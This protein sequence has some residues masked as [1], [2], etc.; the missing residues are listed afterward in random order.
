MPP[1]FHCK[2]VIREWSWKKTETEK[3]R[4]SLEKASI[5]FY[6]ETSL[7][8][9]VDLQVKRIEKWNIR[10]NYIEISFFYFC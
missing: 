9:T 10:S 4:M 3:K 2:P 5:F 6:L 1:P 8:L 7:L